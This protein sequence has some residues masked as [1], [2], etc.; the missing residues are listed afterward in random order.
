MSEDISLSSSR[1]VTEF[2]P[3]VEYNDDLRMT[4]VVLK[5]AAILWTSIGVPHF[6]DLGYDMETGELVGVQVWSDVRIHKQAQELSARVTGTSTS[7]PAD[8]NPEPPTVTITRETAMGLLNEAIAAA[9]FVKAKATI[10]RLRNALEKIERVSRS[11]GLVAGYI[12]I[13]IVA[14]TALSEVEK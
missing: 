5:D 3:C 6:L 11:Y 13:N 12:T 10:T 1:G 7:A 14:S 9:E 2:Q 4:A 8:Q